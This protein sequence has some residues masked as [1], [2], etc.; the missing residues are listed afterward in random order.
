MKLV[1]RLTSGAVTAAALGVL[2][3]VAGAGV[4]FGG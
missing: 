2:V 1:T 4:K 3:T